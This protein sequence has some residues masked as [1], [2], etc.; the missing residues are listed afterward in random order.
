MGERVTY[1]PAQDSRHRQAMMLPTVT[2]SQPIMVV[3]AVFTPQATVKETVTPVDRSVALVI[4]LAPVSAIYMVLAI[5]LALA[6]NVA[7]VWAFVGFA[8][9]TW[10]SYYSLDAAERYDS[11]TGV[12]HHRIDAAERLASQKIEA[13]SAVRMQITR[14]YLKQLEGSTY[15]SQTTKQIG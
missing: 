9:L 13:D 5:A 7:L 10:W 4:R 15:D 8:A 6:F 14:A 1:V 2:D 11:A 3:D 12:E